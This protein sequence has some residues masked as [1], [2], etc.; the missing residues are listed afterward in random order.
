MTHSHVWHDLSI[1]GTWP[2]HMWDIASLVVTWLRHDSFLYLHQTCVTWLIH[3]CDMTYPYVGHDP[4]I[5]GTWPIHMWDIIS[6]VMS[7]QIE[8]ST[9]HD[10]FICWCDW[11]LCGTW[12]IFFVRH[13]PFICWTWLIHMWEINHPCGVAASSRLLQITGLFCKRDL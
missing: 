10:S 12:L 9:W 8:G 2:I 5:C 1:C 13:D 6:L 4:F 7:E 3:M 11:F